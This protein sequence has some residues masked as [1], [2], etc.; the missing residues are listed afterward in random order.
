MRIISHIFVTVGASSSVINGTFDDRGIFRFPIT[1]RIE[2]SRADVVASVFLD[3]H[4][5]HDFR[6]APVYRPIQTDM[7][8]GYRFDGQT[9]FIHTEPF[10]IPT[11]SDPDVDGWIGAAFHSRFFDTFDHFIIAPRDRQSGLLVLNPP[12]PEEYALDG[13]WVYTTSSDL[14]Y[15]QVMASVVVGNDSIATT[16]AVFSLVS[17]SDTTWIPHEA[18]RKIVHHLELAGFTISG[19]VAGIPSSTRPVDPA[20]I[21]RGRQVIVNGNMDSLAH[22]TIRIPRLSAAEL[23][24]ILPRI[25]FDIVADENQSV[26]LS[27]YPEDYIHSTHEESFISIGARRRGHYSIATN[28]LRRLAL[29]IDA[30][31]RR[32]GFAEPVTEI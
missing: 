4:G 21:G 3:F 23:A 22:E 29:H 31:D 12:R 15:P 30:R 1:A 2:S 13:Q 27:L 26:R 10:E 24:Q 9:D 5:S 28:L 20:S 25:H 16:P 32:I 7:A 19:R 11:G 6:L 18:F 17:S 8:D 14:L